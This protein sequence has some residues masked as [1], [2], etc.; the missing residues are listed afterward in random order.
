MGYGSLGIGGCLS[1]IVLIVIFMMFIES[2]LAIILVTAIIIYAYKH[3]KKTHG[4]S[5]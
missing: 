4:Y 1:V 2:H 5:E 3:N